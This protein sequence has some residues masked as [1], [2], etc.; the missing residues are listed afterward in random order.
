MATQELAGR[1]VL[2]TGASSGIGRSVLEALVARGASVTAATRSEA[3][4][5]PILDELKRQHPGADVLWLPLDLA[6]LGSVRKAAEIFVGSERPLHVLINN[7]GVAGAAGLTVDGFDVTIGT[8]HLGTFLLTELLLPRLREAPAA[9]IVNVASKASLR[10]AAVD[11]D[12]LTRPS[13]GTRDRLA[14]YGLSKLF[15]VMHAN[16]LARRL[17]GTRVTTCSLHPGVIASDV[18][19][20]VPWPLQ[21]LMKLFMASNQEGA[22]PVLRCALAPELEGISGRYYDR[23]K[24]APPNPL[25][26]DAKLCA[27]LWRRSEEAVAKALKV[28]STAAGAGASA[29]AP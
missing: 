11:W 19:R 9:R 10:V 20:E 6:D 15:N 22:E 28:G 23:L 26:Q 16:E 2:L 18:W 8:N 1:S 24:E 7:A 27:E 12:A 25:A 21:A 5:R 4:T 17:E 3:K 29:A 13:A 14:R